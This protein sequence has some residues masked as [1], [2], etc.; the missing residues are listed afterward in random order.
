MKGLIKLVSTK[1]AARLTVSDARTSVVGKLKFNRDLMVLVLATLL[2]VVVVVYKFFVVCA[3]CFEFLGVLVVIP[4]NTVTYSAVTKGEVID[5]AVTACYG[6]FLS[7]IFRTMAV[8]LTV[9]MYGTFVGTK[10]PTFAKDC[11]S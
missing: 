11:T 5:R 1:A 3:I 6:C 9:I 2:T 8:T 10:L 4:L 7:Y